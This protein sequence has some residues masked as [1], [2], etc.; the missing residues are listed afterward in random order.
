MIYKK[1]KK[2]NGNFLL[3]KKFFFKI[4]FYPKVQEIK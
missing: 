4:Y 1:E 3:P 2:F